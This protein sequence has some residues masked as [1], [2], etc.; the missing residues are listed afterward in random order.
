[1]I[2]RD[3][4]LAEAAAIRSLSDQLD[5]EETARPL[6]PPHVKREDSA[7]SDTAARI[8]SAVD[9]IESLWHSI[10]LRA[11]AGDEDAISDSLTFLEAQPRF[12]RSGY[13]AEELM[14]R[15]VQAP[16]LSP[17]VSR[18]EVVVRVYCA[19]GIRRELASA[20]KLAGRVWSSGL[21]SKLATQRDRARTAGRSDEVAAVDRL[22]AAAIHWRDSVRE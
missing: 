4:L 3:E 21:E 14:R 12:F 10:A 16:D 6:L 22:T 7:R 20:S 17:F 8:T 2:H 15:L 5:C 11:R 9:R 1:M 18:V 19:H 13:L